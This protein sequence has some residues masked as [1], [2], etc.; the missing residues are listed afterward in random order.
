MKDTKDDDSIVVS[1][2]LKYDK[3]GVMKTDAYYC[4]KMGEV[5]GILSFHK[6]YMQYDAVSSPENDFVVCTLIVI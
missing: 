4:T 3:D 2:Y 6:N 5:K 1:D